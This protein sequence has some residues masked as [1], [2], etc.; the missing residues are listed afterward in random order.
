MARETIKNYE[1]N[2]GEA[3]KFLGFDQEKLD[4]QTIYKKL[5]GYNFIIYLFAGAYRKYGGIMVDPILHL[6]YLPLKQKMTEEEERTGQVLS[7]NAC[8][9]GIQYC[10]LDDLYEKR[11]SEGDFIEVG[12][13]VKN[14]VDTVVWTMETY[15]LPLIMKYTTKDALRKLYEDAISLS[16]HR[17]II[18]MDEKRKLSAL[19]E[20]EQ[21]QRK[22]P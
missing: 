9:F 2:L 20:M 17:H 5:V 7:T 21:E 4:G 3:L 8:H 22:V 18:T 1:K 13:S 14:A 6:D 15:A 16:F 12:A 10:S 19:N 11:W